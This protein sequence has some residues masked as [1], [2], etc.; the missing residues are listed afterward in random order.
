MK[1]LKKNSLEN[2][3]IEDQ[4]EKN[5]VDEDKGH[6][7]MDDISVEYMKSEFQKF[8]KMERCKTSPF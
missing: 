4:E 1:Q 5:G 8:K 2:G 6:S 7:M 3:E